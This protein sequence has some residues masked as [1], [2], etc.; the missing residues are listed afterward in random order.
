MTVGTGSTVLTGLWFLLVDE[1]LQNDIVNGV[2]KTSFIAIYMHVGFNALDSA[3]MMIGK[4]LYG[5]HFSTSLFIHHFL[6]FSLYSVG[7]YYRAKG[8]YIA[9]LGFISEMAGPLA[10][11][12]WMMGK[13]KLSHLPVWRVIQ[14]ISVYIWHF[15]TLLELYTFYVVFKNWKY[16]WTDL[17]L[18]FLSIVL[19]SIFIVFTSLT[20]RWTMAEA[21]K[22]Y[23]T[24]SKKTLDFFKPPDESKNLRRA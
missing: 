22:L 13:A 2:T 3:L 4:I 18:P 21:K 8:H 15:R 11:I 24:Y 6:V 14:R 19:F 10:Y 16:V 7:L 12:N 5:R 17:P 9:M 1:T 23:K 20:P